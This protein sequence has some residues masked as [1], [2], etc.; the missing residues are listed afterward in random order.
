M[1]SDSNTVSIRDLWNACVYSWRIVAAIVFCTLII[2]TV[3]L[4]ITPRLYKAEMTVATAQS[5]AFGTNNS[6]AIG[7]LSKL[8]G[9]GGGQSE[10]F[11]QFQ[12][13]LI[14]NRVAHALAGIPEIRALMMR[15][16][17]FL[18]RTTVPTEE[19]LRRTIT[20]KLSITKIDD[21]TITLSLS[22]D[23]PQHAVDVLNAIYQQADL[24]MRSE[25]R[26]ASQAKVE[27]L[28][29]KLLGV[30][31]ADNKEV[32]IQLLS[33]EMVQLMFAEAKTPYAA[34][35]LDPPVLPTRPVGRAI[36]ALGIA[37]L[38][39]LMIGLSIALW[40]HHGIRS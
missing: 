17:R 11:A 39:G 33:E 10:K 32:L 12:T 28:Q 23:T 3:Y 2:A 9:N 26:A 21:D 35:V 27:Y 24:A 30:Q 6:S 38:I 7:A 25:A 36:I 5:E 15:P 31:N 13:M 29:N 16:N 4:V 22:M 34:T 1:T 19:D 20:S 37:L 40:R 8:T 18:F 14:S